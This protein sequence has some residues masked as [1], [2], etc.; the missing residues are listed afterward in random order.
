M[1]SFIN[2]GT[3]N[4]INIIKEKFDKYFTII[5]SFLW[6]IST[7]WD[8]IRFHCYWSDYI[9]ELYSCF[10]FVFMALYFILPAKIPKIITDKFGFIQTI[11]GRSITMIFFSILFLGDKHLFH[12]LCSIFLFVGG[13]IVLIM[14]L[15]SPEKK[16]SEKYYESNDINDNKN[17]K[18]NENNEDSR[19]DSNPPTKLDDDSQQGQSNVKNLNNFNDFS[20]N[21]NN[22]D[23]ENN[24]KDI[25]E[26]N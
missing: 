7:L 3:K 1:F 5:I 24:N 8:I 2:E 10:F 22:N 11:L 4:K 12:K 23:N 16:E 6:I 14:E 19:N 26:Q 17:E 9:L 25:I 20:E 21:G 13:I 18:E 15:I